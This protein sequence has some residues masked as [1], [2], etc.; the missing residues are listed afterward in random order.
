MDQRTT[1]TGWRGSPEI[2]LETAYEA[3]IESG[4]DAVRILPLAQKLKLSRTS[5]Y[6]FFKDRDALL[7]ALVERW[8]TKN[9]GSIV[10]QS[11]AYAESIAEAML[12]V[13]DCWLDR[14]LFDAHFEFAVRSWGL[15]SVDVAAY[16]NEADTARLEA[17]AAMFVR[18]GYNP[19]EA[20]VRARTIY[21][22][23]IGYI[24][25]KADEDIA[26]RMRRIPEYVE[27]FTGKAPKPREIERFH[28]RHSF[29]TMQPPPGNGTAP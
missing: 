12:N 7:A 9:T 16:V 25:M 27:I 26:L 15:Q 4:I 17:L 23:Q 24:S 5:F 13:F 19:L 10:R 29:T 22:V 11:Q 20:D 14:D 2:W 21:L 1:D 6:W 3:L 8:R 18:F 28:A